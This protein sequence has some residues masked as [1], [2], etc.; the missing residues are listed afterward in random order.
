[1]YD[2]II[3]GGGAA[4]LFLAANMKGKRVLL[5]EKMKETGKKILLS[6]GGMCNLT[7]CDSTDEFL[8]RFGNKK[9]INFIKPALL[10]L[11]TE[12][13]QQ[14]FEKNGLPLIIR[15]D[16]KVFPSS[17][18]ANSVIDVLLSMARKNNVEIKTSQNVIQIN[19]DDGKFTVL[20]ET[21]RFE[22]T[23]AVITT[24]GKSYETTGSDGSGYILAKSLGHKILEPTQG[25]RCCSC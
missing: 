11:T 4:G 1:M 6:G 12:K 19:N 10:N 25:T 9:Q 5:L 3:I 8:T 13:T 16:G 7:N 15:D 2:L 21:D 17:L 14:W 24:G 22:S 23:N 20:T 18:K